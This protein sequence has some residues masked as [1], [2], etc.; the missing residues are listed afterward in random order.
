ME[1]VP[2]IKGF[3][4]ALKLLGALKHQEKVRLIEDMRKKDPKLAS[5][6]EARLVKLEDIQYLSSSMLLSFLRDVDLEKLGLALRL[7]PEEVANKLLATVST[8]IRLDI[9]DG[10]K[11]KLCQISEVENAYSEIL[12]VFTEKIDQGIIKIDKDD[13]FV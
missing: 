13:Q 7:V 12:T 1:I 11:K 2:K 8:G 3:D 6:L 4:E 10:L 9:E 5:E